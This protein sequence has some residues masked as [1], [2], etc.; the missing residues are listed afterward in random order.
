MLCNPNWRLQK[1]RYSKIWGQGCIRPELAE[2]ADA[3]ACTGAA[4][5]RACPR[6]SHGQK[7]SPR[8]IMMD[9]R[10]VEEVPETSVKTVCFNRTA[11]NYSDYIS[12]EELRAYEL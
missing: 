8:K 4:G 7:L 3:Y 6:E 10:T 9:T 5:V 1:L 12:A 11:N 2:P